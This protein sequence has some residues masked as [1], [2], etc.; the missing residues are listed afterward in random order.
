MHLWHLST[1]PSLWEGY[2]AEVYKKMFLKICVFFS[3]F[4]ISFY[5]FVIR[6]PKLFQMIVSDE[7]LI[8]SETEASLKFNS[9]FC[10]EFAR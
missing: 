10:T 5:R 2:F 7:F 3:R 4:K 8:Q 6:Q 9:C 1:I